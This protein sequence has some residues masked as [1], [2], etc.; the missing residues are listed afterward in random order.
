MRDKPDGWGLQVNSGT[1]HFHIEQFEDGL[2]HGYGLSG[3]N[4]GRGYIYVS[5]FENGI[6]NGE[7]NVLHSSG[8]KHKG[9]YINDER[10]GMWLEI[11]TDGDEYWYGYA[12]G[13]QVFPPRLFKA[14]YRMDYWI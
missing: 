8:S 1:G 13:S 5:V 6:R 7:F 14:P 9:Q 4:F 3:H 12:N 11:D 2:A 10:H